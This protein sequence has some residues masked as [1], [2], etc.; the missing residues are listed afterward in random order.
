MV[1]RSLAIGSSD[2][3]RQHLYWQLC[4]RLWRGGA[5]YNAGDLT[6]T[7][8]TFSNNSA[9]SNG[10]AISSSGNLVVTGS[11]FIDNSA[12]GGGG[13]IVDSGNFSGVF[14]ATGS[15]FSGNTA[16]LGGAIW[17]IQTSGAVNDSTISGNLAVSAAMVGAAFMP[18]IN[19]Q[20]RRQRCRGQ[21]NRF[22]GT[23]SGC[24]S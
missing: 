16:I 21:H 12:A 1:E 18:C 13:A 20:Y 24:L 22:R 14:T 10:G 19:P 3:D 9:S 5:I 11:A 7:G 2:D 4:W 8:S 6:V 15:T 17:L 23:Q